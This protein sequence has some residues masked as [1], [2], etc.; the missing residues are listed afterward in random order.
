MFKCCWMLK[1]VSDNMR[2]G[3]CTNI[4]PWYSV[5]FLSWKWG[6][7]S[8]KNL[9]CCIDGEWKQINVWS[10]LRHG[11]FFFFLVRQ[12]ADICLFSTAQYKCPVASLESE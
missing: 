12:F 2:V 11:I 5:S 9:W 7:V 8:K 6:L 10:K 1:T 4:N 3:V